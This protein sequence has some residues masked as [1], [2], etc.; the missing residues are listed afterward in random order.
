[1]LILDKAP[2]LAS[3]NTAPDIH[4]CTGPGKAGSSI[5]V[6]SGSTRKSGG[7]PD[8]GAG[9]P[10]STKHTICTS[11]EKCLVP[12]EE[13]NVTP[14]RFRL[15]TMTWLSCRSSISGS[16]ASARPTLSRYQRTARLISD[17]NT[18]TFAV[19]GAAV[20]HGPSSASACGAKKHSINKHITKK[21]DLDE[22]QHRMAQQLDR[23]RGS[24]SP[25]GSVYR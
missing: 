8:G 23:G 2:N 15:T 24:G 22:A 19:V 13:T 11:R 21:I 9:G 16:D 1:M 17:T 3:P 12:P 10:S 14:A 20:V 7:E 4:C 18:I 5:E 6:P 25:T